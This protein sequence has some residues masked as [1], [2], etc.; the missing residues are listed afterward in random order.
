MPPTSACCW[1]G[2]P[3]HFPEDAHGLGLFDGTHLYEH[4]DRKEGFHPDWNT[5]VFNFGRREVV[6]YLTSNA[7]YWLREHHIDGLR[8]DAGGLDAVSRLFPCRG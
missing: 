2:V 7:I 8:V 5:L 4:A 3:G 6:N 1:I